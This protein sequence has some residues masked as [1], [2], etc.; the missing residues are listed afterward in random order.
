MAKYGAL[1]I[2]IKA[3]SKEHGNE[4]IEHIINELDLKKEKYYGI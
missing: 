4:I 1:N 3:D 2:G